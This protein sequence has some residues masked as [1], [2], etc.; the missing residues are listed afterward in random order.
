LKKKTHN[1]KNPPNFLAPSVGEKGKAGNVLHLLH[2]L[3]SL[4][5]PE[6]RLVKRR[7]PA[8]TCN[9][10]VFAEFHKALDRIFLI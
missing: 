8:A 4:A 1:P 6:G 3:S 10:F 7:L 2:I 9:L 5:P